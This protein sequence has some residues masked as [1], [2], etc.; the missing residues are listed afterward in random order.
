V[1][2]RQLRG[3]GKESTTSPVG[4]TEFD[5]GGSTPLLFA[6]RNGD[7]ASVRLLLDA[8]ADVNDAAAD[9]NSALVIAAMSGH[10]PLASFLLER[11]AN[12]NASGAGYTAMHAAVLRSDPA[13]VKALLARGANPNVRLTKG[14][15]VP[16]WTYQFVLTGKQLGATPFT[17]AAKFGEPE[18][19]RIL[20]DGGAD[21]LIPMNDGTTA[22]MAAA[23]VDWNRDV[24]RRSRLIAPEL[25][26]AEREN[27][28][29]VLD[30]VRAALEAGAPAATGAINEAN[31]AGETA[32]HGAANNQFN[33]VVELLLAQGG[34]LDRKNKK[35][36]TPRQLLSRARATATESK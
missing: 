12:P 25:I 36:V 3:T 23:G 15:P 14:T 29:R 5:A 20:R 4:S 27:E 22:L 26:A 11:G 32:L 10:G 21:P 2:V 28:A 8:G 9:G 6:A 18:I 17:L 33:T 16:R 7:V 19:M 34:D 30:T 1:T 24:D 13:L 31:R 35:G